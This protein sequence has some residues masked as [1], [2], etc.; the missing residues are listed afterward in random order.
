MSDQDRQIS[1]DGDTMS[2]ISVEAVARLKC[3]IVSPET[4]IFLSGLYWDLII[5]IV[6]HYDLH[7]KMKY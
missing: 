3:D 5:F 7:L 4:E 6:I 1:V 2:Q